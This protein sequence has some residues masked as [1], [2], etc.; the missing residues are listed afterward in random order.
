MGIGSFIFQQDG[1]SCQ[2][3]KL[4]KGYMEEMGIELL[5]WAAQ[6][7]DL[8]PIEH[9]WAFIKMKLSKI[10]CKNLNELKIN[11]QEI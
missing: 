4:T 7:P 10:R 5:T 3:S 8:N 11:I 2:T 9:V 6:S 1:A